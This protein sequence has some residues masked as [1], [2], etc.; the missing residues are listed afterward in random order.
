MKIIFTLI[1]FLFLTIGQSQELKTIEQIQVGGNV[2]LKGQILDKETN[3]PIPFATLILKKEEIYRV[4]DENGLFEIPIMKNMKRTAF[5]SISSMGFE[6]KTILLNELNDKTFLEPKF[7]ELAE[8]V[9]TGYLS[10]SSVLE[11]AIS[12]KAVN[13]PVEP[14]NFYRYSSML[15]NKN[16]DT[17]LDLEYITKEYDGSYS[18]LYRVNERVEQIKWNENKNPKKFKTTTQLESF[19]FNAIRYASILHKR[20]FKKFNLNFVKSNS[21]L[22]DGLYVIAFQTERN[23][24][25]NTGRPFPTAYSGRVYIDRES[26]SIVKVVENRETTLQEDEIKK[27]FTI[28][29]SNKNA[30]QQTIKEESICYYSNRIGNDRYYLTKYFFRLY[31]EII[32]NKNNKIYEVREKDAYSFDFELK[33]LEEIEYYQYNNKKENSLFRVEYD[34]AFWNSF[35]KRQI[36]GISKE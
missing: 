11:M 1:S 33:E 27:Y 7:G 17:E 10:P 32:D 34:K 23:N 36:G 4:A 6:S 5:V 25:N 15:I 26:F 8:I 12:K 14:F 31:N 2:I 18:S 13:N 16:D 9:I 24:F 3:E 21:P 30:V 20:K 35:Y 22:D 19:R 29:E 28:S